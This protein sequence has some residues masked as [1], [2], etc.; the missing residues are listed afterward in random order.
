LQTQDLGLSLQNGLLYPACIWLPVGVLFVVLG[1][2]FKFISTNRQIVAT[3]L[4]YLS[5]AVLVLWT[6]I[7]VGGHFMEGDKDARFL[8]C[9]L[10]IILFPLVS[11]YAYFSYAEGKRRFAVLWALANVPAW[12]YTYTVAA[13]AVTG[14][15]L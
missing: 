6:V 13:M 15:W 5:W 3:A 7:C 1:K 9:G 2:Q 12:L 4:V 10:D 8:P 11:I 14:D